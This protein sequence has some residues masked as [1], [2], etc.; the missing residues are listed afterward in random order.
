MVLTPFYPKQNSRLF[1]FCKAFQR[2]KTVEIL[3]YVL[4]TLDPREELALYLPSGVGGCQHI[5]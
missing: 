2:F 5:D 4:T 3:V 1:G